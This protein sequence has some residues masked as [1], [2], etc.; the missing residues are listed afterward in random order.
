MPTIGGITIPKSVTITPERDEDYDYF[1]SEDGHIWVHGKDPAGW[2]SSFNKREDYFFAWNRSKYTWEQAEPIGHLSYG[3][4]WMGW[5][6]EF[7]ITINGD[8]VKAVWTLD[9]TEP[10]L[11]QVAKYINAADYPFGNWTRGDSTI[12][13]R[14]SATSTSKISAVRWA[15]KNGYAV[16]RSAPMVIWAKLYQNGELIEEYIIIDRE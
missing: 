3:S 8:N 12:K 11:D 7:T 2:H 5:P 4:G 1:C 16:R 9:G 6:E 14:G 10:Q 15:D 13:V